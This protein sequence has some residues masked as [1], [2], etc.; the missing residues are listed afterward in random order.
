MGGSDSYEPLPPMS[1]CQNVFLI[2]CCTDNRTYIVRKLLIFQKN[3][4]Y[5][6][7]GIFIL[8]TTVIF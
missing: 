4:L 6:A 7:N 3:I 5:P 8:I 1:L 2:I